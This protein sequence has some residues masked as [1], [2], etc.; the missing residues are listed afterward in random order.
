VSWDA[1][2]GWL[3]G[4]T[5]PTFE[6]L[7]KLRD[8]LSRQNQGA[9]GIVPLGYRP[10]PGNN[11]DG[12]RGKRGQKRGEVRSALTIRFN[13]ETRARSLDALQWGLIPYWVEDPKRAQVPC[14][15]L[16]RVL[17][18]LDPGFHQSDSATWLCAIA[19]TRV[20]STQRCALFAIVLLF[21]SLAQSAPCSSVCLQRTDGRPHT[22]LRGMSVPHD[23]TL[24][25]RL[26]ALSLRGVECCAAPIICGAPTNF[27]RSKANE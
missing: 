5:K 23:Q 22:C 26:G 17:R 9:G 18:A 2:S 19:A 25:I 24:A 4:K 1:L 6:S 7:L 20:V 15:M 13:P 21:C 27:W 12:R 16:L 10:L 8:F 11:P 3:R 14:E